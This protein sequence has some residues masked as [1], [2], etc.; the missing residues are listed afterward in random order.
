[1]KYSPEPEQREQEQGH[2]H[3]VF[4]SAILILF[5]TGAL[6]YIGGWRSDLETYLL[7]IEL[8]QQRV[9]ALETRIRVLELSKA[10]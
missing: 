8:L 9:D 2:I 4:I 5:I 7:R 10:P 6:W 1:M 3:L